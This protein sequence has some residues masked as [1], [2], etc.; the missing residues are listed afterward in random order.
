MTG[1]YDGNDLTASSKP[2]AYD[3]ATRKFTADS[4]DVGLVD[5][6]DEYAVRAELEN[7]AAAQ[8]SQPKGIIKFG[9]ACDTP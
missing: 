9:D 3:S 1:V 6:Q 4:D 7:W 2:L 5:T 8:K